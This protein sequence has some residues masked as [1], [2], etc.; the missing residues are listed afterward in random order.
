[1]WWPVLII[2]AGLKLSRLEVRFNV[3]LILPT[4]SIIS[5]LYSHHGKDI[6]LLIKLNVRLLSSATKM[7]V[8]SPKDNDVLVSV[9]WISREVNL[10]VKDVKV[11]FGVA[12]KEI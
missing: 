8:A 2:F 12:R 4:F 6:I 11:S 9:K 7:C 3:S 1:M 10:A 5:G